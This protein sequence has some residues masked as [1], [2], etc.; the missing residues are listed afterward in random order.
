MTRVRIGSR[1]SRLALA[2]TLGE[3]QRRVD[4]LTKR[5]E[6]QRSQAAALGA[7]I[8]VKQGVITDAE[9]KIGD[10][11]MKLAETITRQRALWSEGQS[12]DARGAASES[13]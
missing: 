11:R 10:D 13:V 6:T 9:Q 3:A 1:G 7:E 2:Q 8:A 5:L 4:T 12:A